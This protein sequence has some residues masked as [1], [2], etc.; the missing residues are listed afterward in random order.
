MLQIQIQE[1]RETV[2]IFDFMPTYWVHSQAGIR[3]TMTS[4]KLL[5]GL[6]EQ[7]VK[8]TSCLRSLGGQL[9]KSSWLPK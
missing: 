4:S 7:V 3:I 5:R 2:V 1:L 9:G 8:E 6:G